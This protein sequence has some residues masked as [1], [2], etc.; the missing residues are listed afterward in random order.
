MVRARTTVYGDRWI[1]D[2]T[3]PPVVDVQRRTGNHP[4]MVA[5]A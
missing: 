5:R 3:H 4:A 2:W 1:G